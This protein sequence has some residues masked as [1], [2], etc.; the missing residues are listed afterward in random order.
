MNTQ[1]LFQRRAHHPSVKHDV[2]LLTSVSYVLASFCSCDRADLLISEVSLRACYVRGGGSVQQ[3]NFL[4]VNI[5][6][7]QWGTLLAYSPDT[8]FSDLRF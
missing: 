8:V 5:Q 6:I 3:L 1:L 2:V 4:G 7:I